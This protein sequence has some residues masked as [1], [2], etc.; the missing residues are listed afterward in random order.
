MDDNRPFF[1]QKLFKS[2]NVIHYSILPDILRYQGLIRVLIYVTSLKKS[3]FFSG[4][5]KNDEGLVN[6]VKYV[7]RDAIPNP[8]VN[9]IV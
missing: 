1:S 2:K 3:H 8:T 6:L 5:F 7:N 4:L 9:T